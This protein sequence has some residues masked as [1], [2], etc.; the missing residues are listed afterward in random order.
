MLSLQEW[1][2]RREII[3]KL[4]HSI[5][6]CICK[7]YKFMLKHY[8]PSCILV[9][10]LLCSNWMLTDI[11][12]SFHLSVKS[13]CHLHL[14]CFCIT[15]LDMIPLIS[16]ITLSSIP[17][18]IHN[19]SWL[20]HNCFPAILLFF[21]A[22]ATCNFLEFCWFNGLSGSFVIDQ[23]GYFGL[24]FIRLEWKLVHILAL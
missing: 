1:G 7:I 12:V 6:I 5:V 15:M 11:F 23:S 21:P 2:I 24:S 22:S 8:I 4:Y 19:Q 3:E 16:C 10:T 13:T 9:W 20:N 17:K 14:L 18:Q